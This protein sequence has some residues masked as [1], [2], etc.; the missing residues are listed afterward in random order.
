MIIAPSILSADMANLKAEVHKAESAGADW[1]HVDIMDGH[2]V[3]NLTFGANVVDAIRPHTKLCLDC[4]LMVAN[5]EDYVNSLAQAGADIMTFHAEAS[6]HSHGLIQ[7][8]KAAGM[9]AGLAINPG[10][11][12]SAISPLLADVDLVLVMTVNPG[13]GGQSFIE[14][15][16]DKM[17]E[18]D[19][20]RQS[21][22]LAFKIEVDG[23]IKQETTKA[24]LDQGVD[25]FVAGSYLY[26]ADNMQQAMQAMRRQ[27]R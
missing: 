26:G 5:P 14:S 23:G 7:S 3:P 11:P 1:L 15:T 9:Q 19:Q 16:L 8:I 10:T 17:A 22:N 4:H 13:F 24:C 27:A 2:F 6:Q 25:V 20:W 12:V 18:L 21:H